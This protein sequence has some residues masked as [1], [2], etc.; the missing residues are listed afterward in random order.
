[1]NVLTR[2]VPRKRRSVHRVSRLASVAILLTAVWC[3][4]PALSQSSP[5]RTTDMPAT[6]AEVFLRLVDQELPFI[7]RRNAAMSMLNLASRE[8]TRALVSVLNEGVNPTAWRAVAEAVAI[9]PHDPPRELW[10]PMSNLVLKSEGATQVAL[11][12]ALARYSV[13]DMVQRLTRTATDARQPVA[14]RRGAII[15]MGHQRTQAVAGNLVNLTDIGQPEPIQQAAFDALITLT[16][17][18]EYGHD[19]ALWLDWWNSARRWNTNRW[20]ERLLANIARRDAQRRARQQVIEQRLIDSQRA[21]YR[22][23][24]PDDRPA[25]LA[26]MLG[27]ALDVIRTL[28][29]DLSLQR[30]VDDRPFDEP[31]R[32]ALRGRISDNQPDIRRRVTLL[33]RDLADGPAADRVAD[34]LARKD[35]QVVAVLRANLLMM[36]RL[37]RAQAVEATME[38]LDERTLLGEAAGALA[39]MADAGFLERRQRQNLTRRV[40][41]ILDSQPNPPAPVATLLGKVGEDDDWAR[42]AQWIDA[43]DPSLKRAAAAAWAESGRSLQIL[44]DRV[45]DPV[46]EPIVIAA[47]TRGGDDPW[48]LRALAQHR[49][50]QPQAAE[51]WEA[52]MVAMAGRVQPPVVLEVV[53]RQE[54]LGRATGLLDRMLTAALNRPRPEVQ[55]GQP[56]PPDLMSPLRLKRAEL[57]LAAG[58]AAAAIDDYD[59]V[60]KAQIDVPANQRLG[61]EARDRMNRGR[62]QAYLQT[63]QPDQAFHV[64]QDLLG[65][66]QGSFASTNDPVID[67]FVE[68]ARHYGEIGERIKARQVL[69]QVRTLL[70]PA[71]KPEVAQRI[72]L[73][74]AE[75]ATRP[76]ESVTAQVRE[77]GVTEP[78]RD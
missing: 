55:A 63:G 66:A 14:A 52:A 70:G 54:M 50:M 47:A 36:A 64:A 71:L 61:P 60:I 3:T 10:E 67:Q 45:S 35:E 28:G 9:H 62:I 40:R 24:V 22:T 27:D 30:L 20:N 13:D 77:A 38:L 65:V 76:G 17:L 16:G 2:S 39:A 15:A 12:E 11:A 7:D 4:A 57:R 42:I 37:P 44:A 29:V 34:R 18:D 5:V 51:A 73:L 31:L 32:Q 74:E 26:Y 6:V 72:A 49:P 58:N 23:T 69:A 25:V 53:N 19:R 43:S 41:R 78:R 68:A 1:V 33:L 48:T 8:S 75:I 21:L 46:I 56:P 59:A